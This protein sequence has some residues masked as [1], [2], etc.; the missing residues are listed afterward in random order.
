LLES[1]K[2]TCTLLIVSHYREQVQR[3]ADRILMLE[4][5]RLQPNNCKS[6]KNMLHK[7]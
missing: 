2:K 4:K 7:N 5:R 3:I 1:L 6:G